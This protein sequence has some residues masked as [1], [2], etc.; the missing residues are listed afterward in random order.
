MLAFLAY[1]SFGTNFGGQFNQFIYNPVFFALLIFFI[2][3]IVMASML[4]YIQNHN[5]KRNQC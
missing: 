5:M 2:S 1:Y 3:S 4:R